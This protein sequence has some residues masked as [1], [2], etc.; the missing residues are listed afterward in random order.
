MQR[1]TIATTSEYFDDTDLIMK[2][3]TDVANS[4]EEVVR[5]TNDPLQ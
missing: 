1:G 3:K 2:V 4:C 5:P